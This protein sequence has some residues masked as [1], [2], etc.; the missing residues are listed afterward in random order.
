MEIEEQSWRTANPFLVGDNDKAIRE[1]STFQKR[2][3]QLMYSTK[4]ILGEKFS[5][6]ESCHKREKCM[7]WKTWSKLKR[8]LP[9]MYRNQERSLLLGVP[10]R[11]TDTK[12]LEHYQDKVVLQLKKLCTFLFHL[13]FHETDWPIYKWIYFSIIAF[14]TLLFYVSLFRIQEAIKI[15]HISTH[16]PFETSHSK[17]VNAFCPVVAPPL[18]N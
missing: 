9:G 11:R 5:V 2:K 4:I 8:A 3:L 7:W 17:G 15:N 14:V 13:F 18:Q 10:C 1:K 12:D 6:V 16:P